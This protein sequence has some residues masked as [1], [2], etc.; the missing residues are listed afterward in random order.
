MNL[1]SKG[2]KTVLIERLNIALSK[3]NKNTHLDNCESIVQLNNDSENSIAPFNLNI[4]KDS[5]IQSLKEKIADLNLEIINL[6]SDLQN[7]QLLKICECK[8]N[9]AVPVTTPIKVIDLTTSSVS[10]PTV[11][12]AS[13]N[14]DVQDHQLF[15]QL[16]KTSTKTCDN[17]NPSKLYILG[18]SHGRNL[19]KLINKF[20]GNWQVLN[21]FKPNA[22]IENVVNDIDNLSKNLTLSNFL[23]V[24]G[25]TNDFMSK[26]YNTY[27][28]EKTFHKLIKKCNH[29]N[30]ILSAVP[31]SHKYKYINMD[32]FRVNQY[33]Y[34][35]SRNYVN[36]HFLDINISITKYDFLPDG[37]LLNTMG[38]NKL[39]KNLFD[40]VSMIDSKPIK[41]IPVVLNKTVSYY[42]SSSCFLEKR[43]ALTNLIY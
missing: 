30:L 19:N 6:K 22:N 4:D 15:S 35:L 3:S 1:D 31:Y 18:D 24:I 37:I 39:I 38:K 43:G 27:K 41:N 29:T 14:L 20:D 23:L 21:V 42:K 11:L 2:N 16:P 26:K 25:G 9:S 8:K 33:I 7:S 12:S 34:K 36:V 28:I 10:S 40:T 13:P 32:I 5:V 17:I